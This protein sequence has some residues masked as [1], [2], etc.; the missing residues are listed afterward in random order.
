MIRDTKSKL[1][2]ETFPNLLGWS[3]NDGSKSRLHLI[4]LFIK[5]NQDLKLLFRD[6]PREFRKGLV[7]LISVFFHVTFL[8]E[9]ETW[10]RSKIIIN[11]SLKIYEIHNIIIHISRIVVLLV[12]QTLYFW[13]LFSRTFS[14]QT[15]STGNGVKNTNYFIRNLQHYYRQNCSAYGFANFVFMSTGSF[16]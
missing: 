11:I 8:C 4:I 16:V 13:A 9:W 10:G 14:R 15:F 7:L 1:T 5:A 2:K 3:R 6:H 12:V